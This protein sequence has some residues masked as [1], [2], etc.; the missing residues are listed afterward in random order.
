MSNQLTPATQDNQALNVYAN[1]T[2]FDHAQRIAKALASS[3]LVPATYQNNISN[4]LVALEM[5]NR[6]GASPLMVMQ[7][8]NVIQGRPSWS[9]TFIIAAINSCGRFAP[10]RFRIENKG[11]VKLQ[12][13]EWV[14]EKHNRRKEPRDI[15]IENI[16]CRAWTTDQNGEVL[17]GPEV[18]VQMAVLEGWYTKTDSKWKTMTEVMLRYRAAS[19]FGRLYAPDIMLGMHTTEEVVDQQAVT[20]VLPQQT[21]AVGAINAQ[22]VQQPTKPKNETAKP[23][24]IE[25]A[26]IVEDVPLSEQ[27]AEGTADDD[28]LI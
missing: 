24:P 7:N 12:Y 23:A 4:T 22:I 10:L 15:E 1:S 16:T 20:D 14:G 25:P 9:S 27:P 2:T 28:D 26:I 17:E 21:N 11:H 6:I 19:F 3:T 8:L 18:S 13:F 5:A